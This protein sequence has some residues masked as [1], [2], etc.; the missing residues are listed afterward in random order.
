MKNVK[1][2]EPNRSICYKVILKDG[3]FK[4]MWLEQ[5][6]KQKWSEENQCIL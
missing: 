4:I 1:I 6:E 3:I 2:N 5:T